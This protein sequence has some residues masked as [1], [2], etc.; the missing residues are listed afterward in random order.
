MLQILHFKTNFFS[1]V[2]TGYFCSYNK[3]AKDLLFPPTQ[4][5]QLLWKANCSLR[6]LFL[7][8]F[9][10][11]VIRLA[12][13]SNKGSTFCFHMKVSDSCKKSSLKLI[14]WSRWLN[15]DRSYVSL[16]RNTCFY[17]DYFLFSLSWTSFFSWLRD[18]D[19]ESATLSSFSR[20]HGLPRSDYDLPIGFPSFL[21]VYFQSVQRMRYE[22]VGSRVT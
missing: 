1:F 6:F 19:S 16:E 15:W 3:R 13:I 9:H 14:R 4:Q 5:L 20:F 17:C 10:F 11:D 2:G 18:L 7:A 21:W 8:S 22:F 12:I